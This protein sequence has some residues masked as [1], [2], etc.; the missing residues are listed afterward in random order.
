M[1][2]IKPEIGLLFWMSVSF[3]TLLFLLGK[4]AWPMILK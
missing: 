1:E 4:F 3:L 2:L